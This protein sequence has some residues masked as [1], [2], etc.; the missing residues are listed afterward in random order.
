MEKVF[1]MEKDML[2]MEKEIHEM[3]GHNVPS[4][5]LLKS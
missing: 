4:Y 5:I 3:C 1:A 2:E